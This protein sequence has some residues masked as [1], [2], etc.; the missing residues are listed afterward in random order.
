MQ[1]NLPERGLM[2]VEAMYETSAQRMAD[3]ERRVLALEER[4]RRTLWHS[5]GISREDE[6]AQQYGEYVDKTVAARILGVTRATVYAMLADGRIE[7]ACEGRRVD[8]RSIARY[9]TRP[10]EKNGRQRRKENA[11]S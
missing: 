7:S 6:L 3:L 2:D 8:V 4:T 9:M 10:A 11:A 5:G 1:E